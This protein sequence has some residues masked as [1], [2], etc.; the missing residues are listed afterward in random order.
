M[1]HSMRIP[2]WPLQLPTD[3][4]KFQISLFRQNCISLEVMI[5]FDWSL[6]LSLGLRWCSRSRRRQHVE[7]RITRL[8]WCLYSQMLAGTFKQRVTM[9]HSPG[10]WRRGSR[11]GLNSGM[12]SSPQRTAQVKKAISVHI[13]ATSSTQATPSDKA[14]RRTIK[15]G[16]LHNIQVHWP[17]AYLY[18]STSSK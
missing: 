14:V 17:A 10:W 13:N 6:S 9:C 4:V 15:A 1:S 5:S 18:L 12:F 2:S 8:I 11:A 7:M 3:L 16:H